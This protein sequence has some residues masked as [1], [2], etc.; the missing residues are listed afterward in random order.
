MHDL[1]ASRRDAVPVHEALR[2]DLARLEP[3]TG[4]VR[5]EHGEPRIAQPVADPRGNRGFGA[6]DDEID[7]VGLR[8]VDEF[9]RVGHADVG[10]VFAPRHGAR[11]AG[12]MIERRARR[13]LPQ[14]PRQRIFARTAPN[15]QDAHPGGY[16]HSTVAG[17]FEVIS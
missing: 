14:A 15:H 6:D 3:A 2:E 16:S 8:A 17:G 10:Q 13:R 11:V 5:A 4:A 1:E 9:A 12:R 7:L